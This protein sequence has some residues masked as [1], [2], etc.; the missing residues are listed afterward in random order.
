MVQSADT[1]TRRGFAKFLTLDKPQ[2]AHF[3]GLGIND[4]DFTADVLLH[5]VEK[6]IASSGSI[7]NRKLLTKGPG[8]FASTPLRILSSDW[9]EDVESLEHE[10]SN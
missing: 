1:R 3:C 7:L 9:P 4:V 6:P 2:N 5:R 10:L 8:A